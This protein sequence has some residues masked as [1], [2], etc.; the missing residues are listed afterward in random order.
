LTVRRLLKAAVVIV[1]VATACGGGAG[2]SLED[3]FA[4][5][6]D[7]QAP[8]EQAGEDLQADLQ[9]KL[10]GVTTEEEARA[11]FKTF[12][13]DSLAVADG[14]VTDLQALEPPSEVEDEH[15]EFVSAGKAIRDALADV[16]DRFD[17]FA[18]ID[19]IVRFFEE[20]LAAIGERGKQACRALQ[21]VADQNNVQV[22]LSCGS[23]PPASTPSPAVDGSPEGEV[24]PGFEVFSA[25]VEGFTIAYPSDWTKTE[26]AFGSVVFFQ[27]PSEG[28]SDAFQE[29]LN[30]LTEALGETGIGLEEYTKAGKMQI[31]QLMTGLDI[32]E[33]GAATLAG[34]PAYLIHY[35][36][37]Q[38]VFELEFL[39]VWT[40][41][42]EVAFV[43]TYTA[44]VGHYETSL[45]AAEEMIASFSLTSWTGTTSQ[46]KPISFT[47]SDDVVTSVAIKWRHG[48][49]RC[50]LLNSG[51]EVSPLDIPIVEG[52]FT[53]Q[54]PS[55]V[56][57]FES[58]TTASGTARFTTNKRGCK[59]ASVTWEARKQG[60]S[61]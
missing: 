35:T 10:Q 19:E 18:S 12:L 32:V 11:L 20:D 29:N 3:Y 1:V 16:I 13:Q 51:I 47:V 48:G 2:P 27:S 40:V 58:D 55:I 37:T 23:S 45:G 46:G 56:G 6:H 61:A 4:G 36:G 21:A 54:D 39:Q 14:L 44:Q 28:A 15:A 41:S 9:T 22:D 59:A 50:P 33:E 8:F 52:V 38:G 7:L 17:E 60:S 26:G 49:A 24:P 25:T 57:T 30:V 5:L 34:L 53:I 43:V 42:E 31:E